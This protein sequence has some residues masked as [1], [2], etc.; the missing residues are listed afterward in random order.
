MRL[1][2]EVDAHL[3]ARSK[4]TQAAARLLRDGGAAGVTT[5]AV[6]RAAGVPAPTIFRLFGD[7]DGLMDAVAEHV[8]AAY[9]DAKSQQASHE[10]G[11]P[12]EDLRD[13]WRTHIDFGLANPDLFVLLSTPGRLKRSPATAAGANVLEA[14]VGRVAAAGLLGISE[15]RTVELI[16]A[17]GTG[18]VFA[19]LHQPSESRDTSLPDTLLE[20][21]LHAVLTTTPAP[22]A[23]NLAPLAIAFRTTVPDLPALTDGERRLLTEWVTRTIADLPN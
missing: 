14:R 9:V 13:A 20:A 6:A 23:S 7:K 18:A 5:R 21:V 16:H 19:L 3:D 10:D 1:T 22:P 15:S 12:V 4:I 8:M 17:A 11:D 2:A